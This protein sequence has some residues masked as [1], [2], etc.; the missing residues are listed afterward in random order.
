MLTAPSEP[1]LLNVEQFLAINWDDSDV[2]AELDRGV[3]RIIRMM[4]GGSVDH[5]R[6]QGNVFGSLY[7]KLKGSGC[8]PHGPDMGVQIDETSL[9][10][11]DVSVYC[12]RDGEL[13]G[14]RRALNDPKL[15]VEV[16]SP[17]TRDGDL[18]VKLPEY[19]SVK[20]L[21]HI[22]YLDPETET[23]RLLT[24]TGPRSWNDADIEAGAVVHLQ[25]LGASLT[26]DDIFAR[27]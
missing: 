13:D 24:R 18:D 1:Y 16:L 17:S 10:Y 21:D 19:R 9:R 6:V 27:D 4:A 26:W 11:P 2:K 12:G 20:S 22:L 5:S 25:A 7:A 8:R 15:V 3:I 23:A 14:K